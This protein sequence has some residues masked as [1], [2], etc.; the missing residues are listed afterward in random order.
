M[1][2]KLIAS[3]SSFLDIEGSMGGGKGGGGGHTPVEA[4]DT[5]SSK[6]TLRLLFAIGEGVMDSMPDILVNGVS[7][8]QYSGISVEFRSGTPDQ[9]VISGFSEIE[10]PLTGTFPLQLK[11]STPTTVE[12]IGAIPGDVTA[13]RITLMTDTLKSV[14]SDGDRV[15][16]SVSAEVYTRP[17]TSSGWTLAKSTTKS[18]KCTSPYAWD[19]R[20]DRPATTDPDLD[21]WGIRV[22]RTSADDA[23][24]QHYSKLFVTQVTKIIDSSRNYPNTCLVGV[25]VSDAAQFN[26]QVPEI[27]F[28]PKGLKL[29]L[30][31]NY[32]V[33]S[34]NYDESTPWTGAFK[35]VEEYTDNLSWAIYYSLIHSRWG[36]KIPVGDVDVGSFYLFAKYCDQLVPDGAGGYEPRFRIDCQFIERENTPT[37]LTY[38]LSLGN[39]QLGPNEFGQVAIFWD[40][41]GQAIT[42]L[43]T[44]ATVIDGEFIYSS[45]AAEE[46]LTLATATFSDRLLQGDT[47]TAFDQ[48]QTLIDR[49]GIQTTDIVLVGCT[50]ESQAIRKCRWA[51]WANSYD[52][53]IITFRKL[54]GGLTYKKGELIN[55]MD[56]DNRDINPHHAVVKNSVKSSSSPYHTTVTLD[57]GIV[58]DAVEYTVQFIID[59]GEIKTDI[60]ISETNGTFSTLVITGLYN[61]VTESSII[62]SKTGFTPRTVKVIGI[63]KDGHEYSVTCASHTE[64]KYAYVDGIDTI[65]VLDS[66]GSFVNFSRFSAPAPTALY[67][68]EVFSSNGVVSSS[69]LA[70]SWLWDEAGAEGYKAVYKASYY[71]DNNASTVINDI[72]VKGFDIPDPVPGVYEIF[73]WAI[74]PFSGLASAVLSGA[75]NYRVAAAT[76]TLVAPVNFYVDGTTGGTF[77]DKNCT[78]VWENP[79]EN[80]TKT[81]KLLDYVLEITDYNTPFTVRGTYT[82]TPDTSQNGRFTFTFSENAAIFGTPQRQ[83]RAR[84][85]CRDMVGDFSPAA[86][87]A[88]NNPVP[89]HNNFSFTIT[90]GIDTAYF[91]IT[92]T[93]SELDLTGYVIWQGTTAG[94]TKNDAAR[95]YVG[96]DTAPTVQAEYNNG[97]S[98]YYAVAAYDSFGDD[99]LDVSSEVSATPLTL[100]PDTWTK[101]GIEF[102]ANAATNT[103]SWTSGTATKNGTTN[104]SISAGSVQWT[105]GTY[106]YIY[107]NPATSTTTLQTT[108]TLG[109]AVGV[110]CWT[111][112]T[113]DGGD[114]TH[115]KGGTGS[116]FFS[117]SQ[118]IAGSVGASALVAG[119]A[120]ITGSAQIASAIIDTVHLKDASIDNA[121]IKDYIQ[122]SNYNVANKTGWKIDKAGD[123]TSY[124]AITF[125]SAG[126]G[127][128]RTEFNGDVMRVYDASNVLRV[129]LGNL[130]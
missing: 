63:K 71:R 48:D 100:N 56:S 97:A 6:Q 12:Y 98:Y 89:S 105:S 26:G 34:R 130:A 106:I 27:R 8:T 17:N 64:S 45:N 104:Y 46:R 73:V 78:L 111:I 80:L 82:V 55:I 53:E 50:R 118:M 113:Y 32:T 108:Q 52:T 31:S 76:S 68:E 62:V 61:I 102:S 77:S 4:S 119:S 87:L 125:A 91:N 129:K 70:V 115:I 60:A 57:R 83:F 3:S 43:E 67:V 49:Y 65:P 128:A 41:A 23:D 28:F 127:N 58:L 69:H 2:K 54:F 121:K 35:S 47:N 42:K 25:T 93:V 117:G 19:I 29:A 7:Y 38:L 14:T 114:N 66:S 24:D 39:A 30:P 85:Y 5:L 51:I 107:F 126:T 96:P 22:I 1:T 103:V 84:V 99:N 79:A 16:Y 44:N 81:D 74:N 9:T 110:G 37:Y 36:I 124:G 92:Q 20:V 112:A 15:G 123:I 18:G 109:V 11:Q 116:A 101:T 95:V 33:E 86:D 21:T 13:A 10:A 122:S 59:S 90:S 75:Y 94:F 72:T 120:V 40:G 88:C